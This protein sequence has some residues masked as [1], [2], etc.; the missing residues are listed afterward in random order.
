MTDFL[1]LGL[2][3]AGVLLAINGLEWINFIREGRAQR[4]KR[5]DGRNWHD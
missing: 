5:W 1:W 3:V 4:R 2:I